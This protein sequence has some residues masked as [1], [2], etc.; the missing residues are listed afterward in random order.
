MTLAQNDFFP[1]FSPTLLDLNLS[2]Q[3]D[4]ASVLPLSHHPA[5]YQINFLCSNINYGEIIFITL[6]QIDFF[7][8]FLP[9]L[10]KWLDLNPLPRMMRQVFHHCATTNVI[11]RFLT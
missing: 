7:A 9:A 11:K 10:R 3:D 5:C 8:S 4:E 1:I 2:P 6:T